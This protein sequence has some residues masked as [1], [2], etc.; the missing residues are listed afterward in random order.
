ML[1]LKQETVMKNVVITGANRGIGLA[2]AQQFKKLGYRVFAVCRQSSDELENLGVSVVDN[3]D[4][5]KSLDLL[6]MQSALAN[7][8]IDILIKNA[9]ILR[10]DILP[11]I[12]SDQ[13]LEQFK[14]NAVAPLQIVCHLMQQLTAGSKIAFITS[15]M[16]SIS[17][18]SS[19]GYYGYRMSKTALNAAAMSLSRDLA[20]QEISVVL[21]HPGW[22]QTQ[23]VNNTGDISATEAAQKLADLMIAQDM[24]KTGSFTHSNGQAL[25]W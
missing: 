15:R 24:S 8:E 7:V 22:V 16:G 10:V 9:G 6:K 21:Y 25:T 13:L 20:P 11:T 17:D 3:I 1:I 4:V 12:S 5:T 2:L 19:G 14:V 23:M 18:N